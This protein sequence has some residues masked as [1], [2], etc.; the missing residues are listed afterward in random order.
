MGVEARDAR[1][2]SVHFKILLDLGLVN[3]SSARVLSE[4]KARGSIV[5]LVIM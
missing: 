5:M 1:R 2:R 4:K 3:K